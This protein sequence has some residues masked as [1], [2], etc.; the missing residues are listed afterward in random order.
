M[1]LVNEDYFHCR[2]VLFNPLSEHLSS[3]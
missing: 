1:A 3:A 2:G